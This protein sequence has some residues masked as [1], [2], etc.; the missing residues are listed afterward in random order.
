MLFR[1]LLINVVPFA[2]VFP[3]VHRRHR[4]MKGA[5]FSDLPLIADEVRAVG[6]LGYYVIL[7]IY[8][9]SIPVLQYMKA[10]RGYDILLVQPD[11]YTVFLIAFIS[12]ALVVSGVYL[13]AGRV[14]AYHLAHAVLTAL[15]A[16]SFFSVLDLGAVALVPVAVFSYLLY[17]LRRPVVLRELSMKN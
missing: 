9:F 6:L 14:W 5:P 10:R 11:G 3:L 16:S 15:L 2:M 8:F 12:F 4:Q 17:K 7:S 1:F 13:N